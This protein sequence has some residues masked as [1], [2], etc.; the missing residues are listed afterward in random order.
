MLE[1]AHEYFISQ[2]AANACKKDLKNVYV[3]ACG[4]E[5][6][7]LRISRERNIHK[8]YGQELNSHDL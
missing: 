6:L 5:S 3:L 8:F 2:F 4:S 1:D 7:L